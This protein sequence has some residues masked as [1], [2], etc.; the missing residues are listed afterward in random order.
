VQL[1]TIRSPNLEAVMKHAVLKAKQRQ[2]RAGFPEEMGLRVHRA[3][4]WL[5]RAEAE[6]QDH[7]AA[8]VFLWIAF[9]AAYADERD[10]ES[11]QSL[12][13]RQQ[14]VSFIDRLV[15]LD[16]EARLY[17]VVWDRFRGPIA[18]LMENRYIYRPF[19]MNRN[20]STRNE[21][22]ARRFRISAND[23]VR[24]M[25][26]RNTAHVLGQVFDRLYMLRCQIMHGGATWNGGVNR[27]QVR[28]A[29]AIMRAVMPVVIDI[30]MDNPEEDW[31]KPF[32]P[33]VN[34]G[35]QAPR[36]RPGSLRT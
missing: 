35:R 13:D 6:S 28:D 14:F 8:F 21:D 15:A 26:D 31:G 9:N 25:A 29:A 34:G 22:W 12:G 4:S 2:L 24:A 5:G 3:L 23:F 11:D 16:A 33:V 7:D 1:P 32:Y 20:N 18:H 30:M 27:E 10:S 36:S 17:A 19:W